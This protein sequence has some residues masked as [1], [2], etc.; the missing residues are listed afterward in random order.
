MLIAPDTDV[1]IGVFD[2]ETLAELFDIGVYD[3]DLKQWYEFEVS[4]YRNDLFKLVHFYH[5]KPFD[6]WVSFNGI[7][8][9]HQ[10]LQF[11]INEYQKWVDLSNIEVC[12]KIYAFVQQLIDNQNYGMFLPYKEESFPVKCIDLYRIHHFNNEAR[13]TS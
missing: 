11:I 2:I 5:S 7:S 12:G 4:S 10:V 3:P 9:D 6:Y 8:F 1:K 13:R